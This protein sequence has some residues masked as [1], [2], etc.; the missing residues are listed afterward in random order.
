M[1]SPNDREN[2]II[3]LRRI[4]LVF[5]IMAEQEVIYGKFSTI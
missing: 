3:M 1:Y 5:F 2:G 4:R